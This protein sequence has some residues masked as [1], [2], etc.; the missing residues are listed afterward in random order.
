MEQTGSPPMGHPPKHP[1]EHPTEPSSEHL[2]DHSTDQ[3]EDRSMEQPADQQMV[4]SAVQLVVQPA[5]QQVEHTGDQVTEEQPAEQELVQP[6]EKQVVQ[7]ADQQVENLA[8]H[9]AQQQVV[10]PAI[11]SVEQSTDQSAE[12]PAEKEVVQPAKQQL[13]RP[14]GR[15]PN[16]HSSRPVEQ[17]TEG[18]KKHKNPG[19]SWSDIE[20]RYI[21][22]VVQEQRNE[23][24]PW[25]DCAVAMHLE[26]RKQNHVRRR[27]EAHSLLQAW[28]KYFSEDAK[29]RGTFDY[30]NSAPLS[31]R[32]PPRQAPNNSRYVVKSH[33]RPQQALIATSSRSAASWGYGTQEF[34]QAVEDGGASAAMEYDEEDEEFAGNDEFSNAGGDM[35]SISRASKGVSSVDRYEDD[36]DDDE[37]PDVNELTKTPARSFKASETPVARSL[38][39]RA[40]KSSKPLVDYSSD[41]DDSLGDDDDDYYDNQ[42]VKQPRK[43]IK[44]V[45]VHGSNEIE[46]DYGSESGRPAAASS[47]LAQSPHPEHQRSFVR[48]RESEPEDTKFPPSTAPRPH[49]VFDVPIGLPHQADIE[50]PYKTP[51]IKS[52]PSFLAVPPKPTPRNKP[53]PKPWRPDPA[54][55]KAKPSRASL[56]AH[57][58]HGTGVYWQDPGQILTY[59]QKQA[60]KREE[61]MASRE[62]RIKAGIKV[63]ALKKP[64]VKEV[65]PP[66]IPENFKGNALTQLQ[67]LHNQQ[68]MD[69][70]MGIERD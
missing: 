18:P 60:K 27:Y 45:V 16:K 67:A 23:A 55:F 42:A 7:R 21:W 63:P 43:R 33:Y 29:E 20:L 68:L 26:M 53:G 17:P 52:D 46:F 30:I 2:M 49:N 13:K 3:L 25:R 31:K 38:P 35:R 48:R 28:K 8:D 41:T 69:D 65:P 59:K 9:P 37:F 61:L 70:M 11:Q 57:M 66:L 15:P 10:Q 1:T 54:N 36:D 14:R 51:S 6:A 40:S 44:G 62:A 4:Q 50:Y 22:D 39:P 64:R 12:Q 34:E 24:M 19:K 58:T 5:A 56:N 47:T 32:P